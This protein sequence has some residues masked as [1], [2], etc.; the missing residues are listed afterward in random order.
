MARR[1]ILLT[2]CL[3]IAPNALPQQAPLQTPEDAYTTRELIAWSQLQKPQPAPQ[4][5]PA[6]EDPIPQPEQPRDQQSTLPADP[7]NQQNPVQSYAGVIV[8]ESNGCLPHQE[9]LRRQGR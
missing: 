5:L 6:R 3:L 7:R 9:D 8:Y 4:P 2:F 1:T